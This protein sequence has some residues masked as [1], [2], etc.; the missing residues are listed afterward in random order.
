MYLSFLFCRLTK[1]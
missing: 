1:Y